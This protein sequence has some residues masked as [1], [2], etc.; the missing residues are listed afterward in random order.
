MTPIDKKIIF[1]TGASGVGKTTLTNLLKTKY[2]NRPDIAFFGFDSIGIPS[3]EQM[4]KMHGS[5]SEWQRATTKKWITKLLYEIDQP[6]IILEGQVNLDFIRE[7]FNDHHFQN[8]RIVLIDCNEEEMLRRLRSERNQPE[9]ANDNMRNWRVYLRKQAETHNVPIINT[10]ELS[11]DA[12][13]KILEEVLW[14]RLN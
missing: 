7:A 1:I 5:P 8:F 6:F 9:L 12:S 3:V 4:I 10:D 13:V 11:L 2:N 14:K